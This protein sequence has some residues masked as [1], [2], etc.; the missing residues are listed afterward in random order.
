MEATV[1]PTTGLDPNTHCHYHAFDTYIFIHFLTTLQ[2][3]SNE[4][5]LLVCAGC[6]KTNSNKSFLFYH[7]LILFS[8]KNIAYNTNNN[9]KCRLFNNSNCQPNKIPKKSTCFWTLQTID[10]YFFLFHYNS[11]CFL[12]FYQ[13]CLLS[14]HEFQQNVLFGCQEL[15]QPLFLLWT[16]H[17]P[18]DSLC[19]RSLT[20]NFIQVMNLIELRILICT[21]HLTA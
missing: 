9:F 15:G 20:S 1:G 13:N 18:I 12:K 19:W 3:T 10:L 2:T 8:N 17:S 14:R 16:G 5:L 6:I 7:L 11:K 21:F 4:A